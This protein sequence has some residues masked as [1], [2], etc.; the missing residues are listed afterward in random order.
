MT[1]TMTMSALVRGFPASGI[2]KMFERAQRY[3][4]V[5]A[6]TFG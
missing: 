2:R 4:N 6:F 5:V 3:D 1:Q